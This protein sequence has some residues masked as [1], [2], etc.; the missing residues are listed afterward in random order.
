MNDLVLRIGELHV[1][2]AALYALRKYSDGCGLDQPWAEHGIYGPATARQLFLG[3]YY[4]RGIKAHK[5]NMLVLE[6]LC[7]DANKDVRD[8]RLR[9][10]PEFDNKNPTLFAK[11]RL[12]SGRFQRSRHQT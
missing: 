6:N 10:M 11:E 9:M 3:K 5:L 8:E 4:K 1:V 2:F 7:L 12:P